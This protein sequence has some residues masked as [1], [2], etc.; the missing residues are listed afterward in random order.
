MLTTSNSEMSKAPVTEYSTVTDYNP[1]GDGP[2]LNDENKQ[3]AA[4]FIAVLYI[5]VFLFGCI[6][7]VLVLI[8]L[9]KYK[10]LR[11]MTDIYLFN[12]AISD[13]I[14]VF[15]LP[16]WAYYMVYE[17]IFGDALCKILGGI[18]LIGFYG[19]SF[20]IILLTLDRYLAIVHAVFS[21]K[22]RTI[23]SGIITSIVLWGVAILAALPGFI[24]HKVEKQLYYTCSPQYNNIWKLF[25]ALEMN[26]L[27]LAIP[28]FVMIFCYTRIIRTLLTCRNIKKKHKAVKLIFII[29]VMFLLFWIPF[30][31][32][33]LL[34]TFPSLEALSNCEAS[35]RLQKVIQWT[36]AISF[37]HC[38]LNPI[39][40][41]FVGEKYRNYLFVFL[42]KVLPKWSFCKF[43]H[44]YV[45]TPDR[46]GSFHTQ[47]TGEHDI[48]AVL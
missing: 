15:S 17:W 8:I 2:C 26:V 33:L 27:G 37:F 40:Y 42:Q 16:F 43:M 46:H 3:N 4:R 35:N 44:K 28:L 7:N 22:A 31:V 20:F 24:F 30:N 39:I 12:L 11:N 23:K 47:S 9:I 19:A 18:Y 34:F 32:A 14:F 13:L 10:K 38:C 21:I 48:S 41:A 6:G 29:L 45:Q 1:F 5:I 36:E 25:T